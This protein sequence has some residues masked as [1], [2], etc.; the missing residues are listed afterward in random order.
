MQE[1]SELAS[2]F[3][4][5]AIPFKKWS[6]GTLSGFMKSIPLKISECPSR[7]TSMKMFHY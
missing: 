3:F 6:Q 1:L 7:V 5:F 4:F 2:F